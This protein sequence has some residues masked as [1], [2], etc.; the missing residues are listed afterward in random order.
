[1]P[2]TSELAELSRV[3]AEVANDLDEPSV[4]LTGSGDAF[5]SGADL[6]DDLSKDGNRARPWCADAACQ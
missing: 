3:F 1:M 5:C 4:V 6:A 2:S